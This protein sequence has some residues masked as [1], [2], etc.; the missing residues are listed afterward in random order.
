MCACTRACTCT[1]THTPQSQA[2]AHTYAHTQT[3]SPT[4]LSKHKPLVTF[5]LERSHVRKKSHWAKSQR[6][7]ARQGHGDHFL[8]SPQISDEEMG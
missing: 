2:C 7:G 8:E 1:R 6:G 5:F 4:K 3:Q